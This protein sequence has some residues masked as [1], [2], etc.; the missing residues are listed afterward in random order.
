[1]IVTFL[2]VLD[3]IKHKDITFTVDEE[4]TIWIIRGEAV[5]GLSLIHILEKQP[6]FCGGSGCASSMC[7]SMAKLL[8][9]LEEGKYQR[10]MVIATGALLS[11]V[12][13]QQKESVPCIAHA[14]VYEREG[15]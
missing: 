3:L 12:A 6:V 7:V 1:M 11:P 9:E 8:K 10:I 4:D 13:V 14:V 5:Y 2:S 15:S